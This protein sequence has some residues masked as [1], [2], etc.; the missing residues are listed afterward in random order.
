ML[1]MGSPVVKWAGRMAWLE[2]DRNGIRVEFMSEKNLMAELDETSDYLVQKRVK[3][4]N[5]DDTPVEQNGKH[6]SN[7]ITDFGRI[8]APVI[9]I[10]FGFRDKELAELR[11][12]QTHP[13]LDRNGEYVLRNGLTWREAARDGFT[14][15]KPEINLND[16]YDPVSQFFFA[17]PEQTMEALE[18]IRQD[19]PSAKDVKMAVHFI[20]YFLEDIWFATD[21]AFA[22]AVAFMLTMLCRE[23]IS[24]N[25]PMLEVRAPESQSGKSTLVKMMLWAI[26]GER[27]RLFACTN[28]RTAE[29]L[30]KKLF[31]QLLQAR[32]YIFM[33]DVQGKVQS[34]LLDAALTSLYV[35]DRVLGAS[36]M[37][38]VYSG[39]PFVMTANNPI[40]SPDI[41]NRVYLLDILKHP[42]NKDYRHKLP[43]CGFSPPHFAVAGLCY[44][45]PFLATAKRQLP[46]TLCDVIYFYHLFINL[47]IPFIN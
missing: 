45:K 15:K 12:I 16:G 36:T 34:S 20:R 30:D 17:V 23:T 41:K 21:S 10:A 40:L 3:A 19:V 37:K 22:S 5:P 7:I 29:E 1:K 33:D 47:I 14:V 6:V 25:V 39:M 44:A 38:T 18:G 32:N 31:S 4:Y 8:P 35:D 42:K 43:L 9:D 24:S 46:R 11:G 27:P 13:I 2:H 26:T 28:M